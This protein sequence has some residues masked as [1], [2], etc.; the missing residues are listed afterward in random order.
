MTK[1]ILIFEGFQDC[2]NL[3]RKF[4]EKSIYLSESL[5]VMPNEDKISMAQKEL[6]LENKAFTEPTSIEKVRILNPK[7]DRQIRQ[8]NMRIWLM[9]FGF[10]A[11]LTFAKM[12]NLSTFSFMG[13]NNLGEIIIGGILGMVSGYLGSIVASASINLNRSK[14]IRSILNYNKDGKWIILL[15]NEIGLELPWGVIGQSES[16]EMIVLEN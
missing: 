12:T 3:L 14:E 4:E 1:C 2:L 6:L 5:V 15:E 16:K 13:V 7:L 9:P 8:K 10:I 11:G